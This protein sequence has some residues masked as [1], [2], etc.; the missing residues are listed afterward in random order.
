MLGVTPLIDEYYQNF[1]QKR[2][3]RNLKA[4]YDESKDP[5]MIKA[6]IG[7]LQ[8]ISEVELEEIIS[9]EQSRIKDLARKYG[10]FNDSDD[11]EEC[12]DKCREMAYEID[13]DF[14]V[15]SEFVKDFG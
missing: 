7:G 4:I 12:D 15:D 2:I 9:L 8:R 14:Y 11:E 6:S 1:F 3:N 13:S 5:E 10:I